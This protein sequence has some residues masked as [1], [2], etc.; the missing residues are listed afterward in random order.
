MLVSQKGAGVKNLK[1]T[2]AGPHRVCGLPR[3]TCAVNVMNIIDAVFSLC[4]P[5]CN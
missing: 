4:Y 1:E 3:K 2:G 5:Y